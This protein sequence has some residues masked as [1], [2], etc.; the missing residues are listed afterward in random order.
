MKKYNLE[1]FTRGWFIG[2]FDPSI[3]KRTDFE[4]GVKV[5]T[6]GQTEA[7]HYHKITTEITV[8]IQGNCK[9]NNEILSEGDIV[10]ISPN[11]T[12]KF[13]ALSDCKLAVVKIPSLPKDK[14]IA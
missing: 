10:V 14:Y 2:N 7:S 3:I 11:E 5:F 8:V 1:K 12:A 6:K 4:V 13:E 9:L